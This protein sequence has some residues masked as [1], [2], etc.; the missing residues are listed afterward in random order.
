MSAIEIYALRQR[1]RVFTEFAGCNEVFSKKP[2]FW[3][4][5][6]SISTTA[7]PSPEVAEVLLVLLDAGKVASLDPLISPP[8]ENE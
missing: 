7:S 4:T 1:N 6:A 3:A 8:G 5:R 2:G